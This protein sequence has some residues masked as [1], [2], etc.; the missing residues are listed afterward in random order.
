MGI[1]VSSY[2]VNA[3]LKV[4]RLKVNYWLYATTK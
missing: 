1:P 2:A 4:E 3:V